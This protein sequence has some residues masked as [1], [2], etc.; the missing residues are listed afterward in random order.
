[1]R[2]EGHRGHNKD[3]HTRGEG[4]KRRD[5]QNYTRGAKT[6]RRGR[7]I[8]FLEILNTKRSTLKQQLSSPELQ[9][10]NPIIAGELKAIEMVIEEFVQL[11]E[12]YESEETEEKASLSDAKEQL[13][14]EKNENN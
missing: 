8:A 5:Q 9:A 1:M 13:N 14:E 11:F 12:L 10:I 7:A 3:R 2:N 6:F 4:Y